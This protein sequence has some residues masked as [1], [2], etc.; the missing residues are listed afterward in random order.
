[1]LNSNIAKKQRVEQ[2][3][4]FSYTEFMPAQIAHILAGESALRLASP[5]CAEFLDDPERLVEAQWFN[6]G[7]QGP[8]IFYHNQR[9]KPSGINYGG[10]IH[11]RNYGVLMEA[12]LSHYL[13]AR[14]F[15]E[16][17]DEKS[18]ALPYLIGFATHAALDR[19]LHP[20][21]V[22]FA[23]WEK[24]EDPASVRY[25][26]CHAFLER[27]LDMEFL[28]ELKGIPASS[29]DFEAVLPLE[30]RLNGPAKRADEDMRDLLFAGISAAYPRAAAADFLLSRRIEN[31]VADARYFLRATNPIRTKGEGADSFAYLDDR[32]GPKSVSVIYPD[33]FP[34]D[35]DVMNHGHAEWRHPAGDGRSS[36]ACAMDLFEN[37]VRE[38]AASISAL[39]TCIASGRIGPELS[40]TI[41][42]GSLSVADPGGIAIAPIVS[43]PLPLPEILTEEFRRRME[44]ARK[45]GDPGSLL[46]Q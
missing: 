28:E 23:G 30:A 45:P 27:L 35:L 44:L 32:A 3:A 12:A 17:A 6:F 7:C 25:R 42:N 16:N 8:D 14:D 36:T 43:D 11:R 5:R 19:A 39:L 38:A 31:A 34:P 1:V 41:G 46:R 9:T 10:L 2:R 33:E 18:P 21:I 24:P 37:G 29:Y 22:Y 15:Y 26:G 20:Y 13:A 40:K 4:V